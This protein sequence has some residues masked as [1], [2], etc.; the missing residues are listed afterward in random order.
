VY[1]VE[2]EGRLALRRRGETVRQALSHPRKRDTLA[3][4]GFPVGDPPRWVE[5]EVRPRESRRIARYMSL[6][7]QLA[8]GRISKAGFHRK[9]SRW[10]P[11]PNGMRFLADP[12]AVLAI[13][14]AR[15]AADV[16]I[17]SYES[18]RA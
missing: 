12:D 2:S 16:E 4:W 8:D 11:L 13:I 1:R 3:R 6:V 9:V 7:G 17:F 18:G 5:A 14:E 15:R 10:R